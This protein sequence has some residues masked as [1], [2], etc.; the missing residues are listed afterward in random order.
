MLAGILGGLSIAAHLN[1]VVVAAA[2]F[3]F[4]ISYRKMFPALLFTLGVLI[5][6]VIYFHDFNSAYGLGFWWYQMT[7]S[8]ALDSLPDIHPLLQPFL[9]LSNE[10]QRFFHN[11]KII[12]STLFFIFSLV[13]GYRWLSKESGPLLRYT[14]LLAILLGLFAMHKSRQY[15]L[16]YFP[17]LVILV[18]QVY[19][20]YFSDGRSM[21]RDNW[22]N[23][24]IVSYTFYALLFVFLIS[25][26]Y[27]NLEYSLQKFSS[28][29]NAELTLRYIT[30]DPADINVVAPMTF[31]FNE[32]DKFSRIQS[33]V[34]YVEFQKT[35]SRVSGAGF[36]ERTK[37][38]NIRYIILSEYY[39]NLLGWEEP[40]KVSLPDEFEIISGLDDEFLVIRRK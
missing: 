12:A 31:I 26:F 14:F 11:P 6:S 29:K 5:G 20:A 3:I 35:D 24:R 38:F 32:I 15:L 19:F 39:R 16:I 33:E 17:F 34:C 4:L 36:L 28:K 22:R 10:H 23:S 27:Y 8:S 30:E 7:N 9:N 40:E 25:G 2:G 13:T 21:I 37:P 1:G 18:S